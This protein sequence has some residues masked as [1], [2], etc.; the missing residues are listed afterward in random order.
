MS[1]AVFDLDVLVA[2]DRRIKLD[3]REWKVPGDPPVPWLLTY[4]RAQ[5]RFMA[6]DDDPEIDSA[7]ALLE[8][9]DSVIELLLLRQPDDEEVIT[10]A[11][12]TLGLSVLMASVELI[13]RS[14]IEEDVPGDNADEP[15]EADASRPTPR[16]TTRKP[17]TTSRK[18]PAAKGSSS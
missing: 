2:P 5:E 18:K 15:A 4:Q 10:K 14:E 7:D 3:G 13:Y 17:P 16:S 12:D 9:R 8:L 6:S 1:P 11:I